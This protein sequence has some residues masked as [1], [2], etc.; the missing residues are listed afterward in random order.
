MNL[1]SNRLEQIS[2]IG[3]RINWGSAGHRTHRRVSSKIES[4]LEYFRPALLSDDEC[5]RKLAALIELR[6]SKDLG[7]IAKLVDRLAVPVE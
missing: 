4:Q 7:E 3:A 6:D 5:V 2:T 1:S